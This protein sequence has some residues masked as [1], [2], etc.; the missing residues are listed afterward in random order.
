MSN[1]LKKAHRL[2]APRVA[3]LVGTRTK[4]GHAPNLIPVSN[5]TS[6]STEPQQIVVAVYKEWETH[7]NL[8]AA[9]GFTVSVPHISQLEGVWKLGAKY[10][11][12]PSDSTADK[13]QSCG[14]SID[15]DKSLHGPILVDGIG[16]AACQIVSK[17]DFSGDHGVY[18]GQ[19]EKV[20]FNPRYLSPDGVPKD[21]ARPVM[22]VT[23]NLFSTAG[24][25]QE[26]P[27]YD[28]EKV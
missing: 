26:V 6:V 1:E 12:Y 20:S 10:S 14:L 17:L 15:H 22:Q 28:Q 13:I 25:I 4:E 5:V 18:I 19:L 9:E 24:N 27:Y 2:F 11:R 3:Y 16:W 7:R 23:G 21:D 8:S